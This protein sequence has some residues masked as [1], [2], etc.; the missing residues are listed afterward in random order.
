MHLMKLT[1]RRTCYVWIKRKHP[2]LRLP[3]ICPNEYGHKWPGT[4]QR[5]EMELPPLVW[6]VSSSSKNRQQ[7]KMLKMGWRRF[8]LYQKRLSEEPLNYHSLI[9]S[10]QCKMPYKTLSICHHERNLPEKYEI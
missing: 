4:G 2:V 6:A 8:L 3:A 1:R 10:K 5:T 9:P 7:V